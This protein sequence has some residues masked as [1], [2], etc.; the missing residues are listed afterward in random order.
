MESAARMHGV[1]YHAVSAETPPDTTMPD[2]A[3]AWDQ[4]CDILVVGSG[5]GAMTAAIVAHDQGGKVLAIEKSDQYGGTSATSGGGV[6]IPCNRYAVAAGCDDSLD[7]A[8]AYI[9]AVSPPGKISDEMIET[10][11]VHGPAM[12]D[13]LH[14][15]TRARYVN[16]VHYPDYFPAEAGGKLGNR[17]MEPQP[18]HARALGGDLKQL[19]PQHPQTQLPFGIN[20]TQV[21]GQVVLGALPGWKQLSAKLYLKYLADLPMRV[22]TMRDGRLTMGNAGVAR[23]RLSMRDRNI[24]LLMNCAMRELIVEDGRVVGAVAER[25]GETLRI[26]ASRGVI[27]AAG[28]FERNQAMREQYLPRPTNTEWSAAN[29]HNTG[30]AIRAAMELGADTDQMDWAWWFTTVRVPGDDKA[31]LSQVEK[32]M[33]GNYTVNQKGERFSNES[34][35]YILFVEDLYEKHSEESSTIP[36]YMVFD[37]D[38]RHQRPVGALVQG[39]LFPDWM[40]PRAWWTPSYLSKAASLRE[41]ADKIGVDPDGLEATQRKVNEYATTGKDLDFQRGDSD[42]D[43]YYAD[44]RVVPNPCLG[45]LKKP[46][47]YAMALYPGEMGTAG[48]LKINPAGQALRTDGEVM[49][50][51]YAC[52]NCTAALLPKYPGPG[53]TLGP[54]MTFGYLAALHA[55][56]Q[57][58]AA[59]TPP[60]ARAAQDGQP[61]AA[62]TPPGARAAQDGQPAPASPNGE[63]DSNGG[64]A[65][66][67][68]PDS[69]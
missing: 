16:L 67:A 43:R 6:W 20:F 14:E 65:G 2:T 61:A 44:L 3:T 40:V 10:Y 45:P 47:F 26:K 62:A 56:G 66:E 58:A 48:G 50:G 5:N 21:E 46:P 57:P 38:F 39:K 12:I 30:D 35:N 60:G 9:Q 55:M 32:A 69:R 64:A 8:R 31:H 24:P 1:C 59:A 63:S 17:S 15:N 33:A 51:L 11:L 7:Q 4:Q 52:G 49:A 22:K 28:G 37:A 27:L 36:C 23:L 53:S 19:R 41:L 29:M 68:Q 25:D 18:L 13:Y 34:Q 42:Y 54:A